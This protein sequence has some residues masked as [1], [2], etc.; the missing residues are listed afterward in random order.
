M[1][2]EVSALLKVFKEQGVKLSVP[3][4][5]FVIK[6]IRAVEQESSPIADLRIV[7]Q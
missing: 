7:V 1:K 4:L 6:L 2:V 5:V 3:V